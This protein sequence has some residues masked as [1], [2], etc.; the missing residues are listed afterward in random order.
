[1]R[2]VALEEKNHGIL[3]NMFDQGN[4]K[5]EQDPNGEGNP[6]MV[7][8]GVVKWATLSADGMNRQFIRAN[9]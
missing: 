4:L 3:V 6:T 1:M 5:T 8:D 2:T 7:V 9:Q